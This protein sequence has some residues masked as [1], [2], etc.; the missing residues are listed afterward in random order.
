MIMGHIEAAQDALMAVD[1]A[2][3]YDELMNYL[4]Y[5]NFDPTVYPNFMEHM[6]GQGLEDRVLISAPYRCN[7]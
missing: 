7:R 5:P 1:E 2:R 6:A 4:S 3:D